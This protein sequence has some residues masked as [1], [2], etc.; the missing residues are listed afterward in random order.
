MTVRR[1]LLGGAVVALAALA[2]GGLFLARRAAT[3]DTYDAARRQ[4]FMT[5]C[6]ADGGELVRP[7]CACVWD[8][9]VA[10]VPFERYAAVD[11]ELGPLVVAQPDTP[12]ELP[13][14]IGAIVRTCVEQAG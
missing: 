11:D 5:A 4:S 12:L 10:T 9:L 1:L 3:P 2:F 7:T 6:I 13:D 14:D 8:E